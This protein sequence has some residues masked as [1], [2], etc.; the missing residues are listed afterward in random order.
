MRIENILGQATE[1][2]DIFF[3]Y[4]SLLKQHENNEYQMNLANVTQVATVKTYGRSNNHRSKHSS[5]FVPCVLFVSPT[6]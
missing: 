4:A 3:Q 2:P 1:W 6:H 5:Q